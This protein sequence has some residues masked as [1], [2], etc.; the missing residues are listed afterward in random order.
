MVPQNT[1]SNSTGIMGD[2]CFYRQQKISNFLTI[3]MPTSNNQGHSRKRRW[4]TANIREHKI[5]D[6]GLQDWSFRRFWMYFGP[7]ALT[8]VRAPRNKK[9]C[10]VHACFHIAFWSKNGCK[11]PFSQRCR[12]ADDLKMN[13]W[14]YLITLDLFF[15]TFEVWPMMVGRTQVVGKNKIDG[16]N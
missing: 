13:L 5:G 11:K 4:T 2:L 16:I 10:F 12:D 8:A 14:C 3:Q 15:M 7:P 6:P 9:T 1:L